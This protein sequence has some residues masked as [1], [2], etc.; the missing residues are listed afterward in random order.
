MGAWAREGTDA[1]SRHL[2][3]SCAILRYLALSCA[4]LR[5]PCCRF[6]RKE[7][8]PQALAPLLSEFLTH[9]CGVVRALAAARQSAAPKARAPPK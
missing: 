9:G 8:G 7:G 3:L 2:A 1:F 4:I 5:Y 6:D